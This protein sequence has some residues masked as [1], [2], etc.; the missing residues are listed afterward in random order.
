LE[1]L[2]TE[3]DGVQDFTREFYEMFFVSL[4]CDSEK[5]DDTDLSKWLSKTCVHN[6]MPGTVDSTSQLVGNVVDIETWARK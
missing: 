3:V 2:D 6:E 4:K 1:G 5:W